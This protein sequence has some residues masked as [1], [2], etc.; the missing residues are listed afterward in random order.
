MRV[1]MKR[2]VQLLTLAAAGIVTL[3][4][5]GASAP[6]QAGPGPG[7]PGPGQ[8]PP[9]NRQPK[10]PGPQPNNVPTVAMSFRN[11]LD[12]P[13]IIQGHSIVGGVQRRGQPILVLPGKV[14]FDIYDLARPPRIT[15]QTYPR[16][17]SSSLCPKARLI[18][19]LPGIVPDLRWGND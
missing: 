14:N 16:E 6:G 12:K 8:G 10:G 17:E 3:L 5:S 9:G 7:Q 11:E 1:P 15:F 19:E 4:G 13:V 2:S 18:F